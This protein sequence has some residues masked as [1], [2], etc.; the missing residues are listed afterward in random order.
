MV[1]LH[2]DWVFE[3]DITPLHFMSSGATEEQCLGNLETAVKN[4][5]QYPNIRVENVRIE[6]TNHAEPR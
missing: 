6:G 5:P 1:I 3:G 2:A 4:S